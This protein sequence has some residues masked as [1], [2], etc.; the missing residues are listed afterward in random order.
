[1]NEFADLTDDEFAEHYLNSDLN[2]E[3]VSSQAHKTGQ[4]SELGGRS[5]ELLQEGTSSKAGWENQ[6]WEHYNIKWHKNTGEQP[7]K[8]DWQAQG[9][10]SPVNN[11]AKCFACYAFAA[12]GAIEGAVWTH[13][14]KFER[15]SAQQVF[16]D[17]PWPSV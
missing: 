5:E 12:C 9:A 6:L 4:T 14:K 7:A 13:H 10:V 8:Q 15:L 11:Q 1:M 16:P 3:A 17:C 2:Q